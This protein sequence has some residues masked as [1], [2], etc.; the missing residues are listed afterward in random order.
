[1][2]KTT[3]RQLTEN[4]LNTRSDADFTALFYR[5]KPG[6]TSYITKMVKDRDV[7]EDI[8]IN[9]LTKLWTKID[10]YKPEY[11]ITTWL[12][13]IAFNDALGYI[14]Q[15]N[16]KTSL[17]TLSEFGVEINDMGTVGQG[18]QGA[19]EDY[20]MKTEQDF[21]D[22]DDELM[23][24]YGNALKAIDSLKEMYKPIVVDRLINNMKYED[25]A[26]KH[27]LPLQT[28]KNRIRRGKALIE[29]AVA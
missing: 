4:F 14:N 25:I 16:K 8:A 9:T 12:Y 26:A 27:D 13:R 29:E 1:M 23:E 3:Y 22:E 19:Y 21:L 7:A 11:Q 28:I 10:Q 5:V 20:E 17:T 24:R 2:Q 15:K 18:L 6:L